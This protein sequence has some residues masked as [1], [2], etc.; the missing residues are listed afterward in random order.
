[1]VSCPSTERLL[2]S[3]V[4]EN[5]G[6]GQVQQITFRIGALIVWLQWSL[7]TAALIRRSSQKSD[8]KSRATIGTKQG[9]F[10]RRR[11]SL[12]LQQKLSLYGFTGHSGYPLRRLFLSYR[13]PSKCGWSSPAC[14]CSRHPKQSWLGFS[15]SSFS[16][17]YLSHCQHRI[18]YKFYERLLL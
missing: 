1:M 8:A 2:N 4:L 6:Q 3:N 14:L 17:F 9:D 13:G 18:L 11:C 10:R 7:W 15:F 5:A 16:L 12:S